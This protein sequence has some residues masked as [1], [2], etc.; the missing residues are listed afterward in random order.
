MELKE[1]GKFLEAVDPDLF[2][3]LVDNDFL[4]PEEDW[5]TI[6]LLKQRFNQNK[7][8][9]DKGFGFGFDT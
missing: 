5:N 1:F 8:D 2:E 3:R 6:N 9:L 4:N 7:E